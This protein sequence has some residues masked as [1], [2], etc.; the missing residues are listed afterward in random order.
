MQ[1]SVRGR[2]PDDTPLPTPSYKYNEWANDRKHLGSTPRLS[3][4]KGNMVKTNLFFFLHARFKCCLSDNMFHSA[5]SAGRKEDGEG[6]IMFDNEDEKEQWQE[7]QRV[8]GTLL[9]YLRLIEDI[10]CFLVTCFFCV[11]DLSNYLI[12]LQQADRDWYMMDEGYDEF[13]NPFTSTSEEYVKKREQILQKQ[14]QKRISA[15]KRQINEVQPQCFLLAQS[16]L[17][18][19]CCTYLCACLVSASGCAGSPL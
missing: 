4:G 16:E 15:Q 5:S 10:N 19:M 14:T 9:V 1:R 18:D 7:D 17:C 8:S 13:H 2:Y 11:C 12:I 3:Q 6:G